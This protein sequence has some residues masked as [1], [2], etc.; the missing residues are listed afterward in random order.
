MSSETEKYR[1]LTVPYCQGS[2]VDIA[3]QGDAVV[4]WAMSFDLP[5][6]EFLKYSSGHPPKGPIHLRGTATKL[7]FDSKSLDFV[8]S[9]HLLEDFSDWLPLLSEWSRCVKIGGNLVILIPEKDLWD[10][11]IRNGQP[12]NNSH[13]HEGRVGELTDIFQRY[14]GHF[15][16]QEDRLTDLYPGDYTI[17]FVAKRIL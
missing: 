12:P 15:E 2:G 7:P 10:A 17:L 14:F 5:E 6:K 8:Y 9:S 1:K 11:A 4:P 16:V 3:S 13:K